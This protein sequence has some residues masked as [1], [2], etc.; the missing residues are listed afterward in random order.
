M[1]FTTPC[2][3]FT[4][5]QMGTISFAE[6]DGFT[7]G[8]GGEMPCWL[9][10]SKAEDAPSSYIPYVEANSSTMHNGKNY[11]KLYDYVSSSS[12]YVGSYAIMP[13][14]NVDDI[15]KYQVNFWGRSYNSSSYNSQ[16]IVGIIT[17]P[18]DL[19]S[20]VALDTLNL[21]KNA[22]DPFSVGFE[23]YM[24][25]YMGDMGSHIM[26]LSEPTTPISLR[27]LWI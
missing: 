19:S 10:G 9:V 11:L 1:T 23:N 18:T 15:T 12:N 22:W 20:F 24:G 25:D 8:S 14:L 2:E 13:E 6:D 26:F 17:D 21:S 7:V 27:Y 16:V 4:P 3:A 5:E